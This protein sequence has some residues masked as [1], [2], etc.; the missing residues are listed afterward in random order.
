MYAHRNED[1]VNNQ[2][3]SQRNIETRDPED[4]SLK[5]PDIPLKK[6]RKLEGANGKEKLCSSTEQKRAQYGRVAQFMGMDNVEFS[7]WVLS[8]TPSQREKVL[9]DFKKRKKTPEDGHNTLAEL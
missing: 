8:A 9:L 6:K 3:G 2:R 1:I 4:G 5:Q 7:K